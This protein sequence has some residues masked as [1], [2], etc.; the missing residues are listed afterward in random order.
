MDSTTTRNRQ[1][2]ETRRV[3]STIFNDFAFDLSFVL[4]GAFRQ[5]SSEIAELVIMFSKEMNKIPVLRNQT[6]P[7]LK[8]TARVREHFLANA[9]PVRMV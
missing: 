9:L 6:S 4:L 1:R 5:R 7:E 3:F 2:V 8:S